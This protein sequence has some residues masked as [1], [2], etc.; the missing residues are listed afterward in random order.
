MS[1]FRRVRWAGV[2]CWSI[3][4]SSFVPGEGAVVSLGTRRCRPRRDGLRFQ[5]HSV[6]RE[7]PAPHRGPD[8]GVGA[9]LGEVSQ[10]QLV[11][12]RR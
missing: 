9:V 1:A 8:S 12:R 6:R 2:A 11:G 10:P 5:R 7:A 4:S 3:A